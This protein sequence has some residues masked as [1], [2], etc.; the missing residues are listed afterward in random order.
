MPISTPRADGF[1]MPPEWAPHERTLM[2]WPTRAELWDALLDA[3]R[4]DYAEIARAIAR[5]EPVTMIAHPLDVADARRRCGDDLAIDVLP[6]PIDDSWVRDSG[7]IG[8]TRAG[9]RAAT[10]FAFN[11]WGEKYCPYAN[12]AALAARLLPELGITGYVAPMTLEGGS[13]TVNGVGI[14]VTTAQCLL[15]P[16]RN[17]RM[18]VGDIEACLRDYLGVDDVIWLERGLVED[19]DTDGH[20]DNIAAFAAADTI[21]VQ[22]T[23]VGPNVDLLAAN[24]ARLTAHGLTVV[25]IGPLPYATAG[26]REVVVPY[27]NYYVVNGGV[28]VPTTGADAAADRAAVDAIGAAYGRPAVAVPGAVLAYGGGGVHCITQQIPAVPSATT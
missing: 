18:S 24:E 4:D 27:L 11:G 2:A 23:D 5:F 20:V 25:P 6:M 28:I 19:L 17:P 12:D 1:S 16:S 15:D 9:A 7:P 10:D 26:G 3:A 14:L 21:L 8:V 13:I 22:H